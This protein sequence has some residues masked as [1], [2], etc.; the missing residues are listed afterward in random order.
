MAEFS[1]EQLIESVS[2]CVDWYSRIDEQFRNILMV[3]AN[4]FRNL[5]MERVGGGQFQIKA[6]TAHP[7]QK[8]RDEFNIKAIR[9]TA[10]F[11]KQ[12]KDIF[13]ISQDVFRTI[14]SVFRTSINSEDKTMVALREKVPELFVFAEKIK[15]RWNLSTILCLK[16][17][18]LIQKCLI[19]CW[20]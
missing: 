17:S 16:Q 4:L 9:P 5:Y 18:P 11:V 15:K 2:N 1:G 19:Y 3:R 10:D 7:D 8:A 6:L 20:N 14:G 12:S 13:R